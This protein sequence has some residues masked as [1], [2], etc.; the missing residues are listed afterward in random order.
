MGDAASRLTARQESILRCLA[1]AKTY[2]ETADTLG[3]G[4]ETVK[5]HMT[6]IRDKLGI[7][8]KTELVVWA[9][10]NLEQNQ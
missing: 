9:L 4:Y 5:S 7:R 8:R 3:L 6:K 2:Q 1:Q 10:K